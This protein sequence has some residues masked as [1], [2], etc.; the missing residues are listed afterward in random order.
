MKVIRHTRTLYYSDGIQVFEARD[1]IGGHYVAVMVK[2]NDGKEQYLVAGVEPERLQQ[3]RIGM[4]DL[5]S[6]LTRRG[7]EEWFLA[8]ANGGL[9]APLALQAQS[10]ALSA[11]SYLPERGFLLHNN[12]FS[13]TFEKYVRG[14]LDL[15]EW[16]Q[17]GKAVLQALVKK[18][19]DSTVMTLDD[20]R[21]A[22]L[23]FSAT[24]KLLVPFDREPHTPGFV[25]IACASWWD[26]ETKRQIELKI[27]ETKVSR[28]MAAYVAAMHAFRQRDR[29]SALRWASL[30]Y[31][32]DMLAGAPR[33]GG[34]EVTLRFGLRVPDEA[35]DA[36]DKQAKHGKRRSGVERLPEWLLAEA[37]NDPRC[38]SLVAPSELYS[39]HPCH[40]FV[41]AAA[42]HVF[43]NKGKSVKKGEALEKFAAF[44]VSTVPGMRPKRRVLA[45]GLTS[46]HDVV[47]TMFGESPYP[48]PG[49]AGEWLIECKNCNYSASAKEVGHFLAKM[50]HTAAT[51]GIILAKEDVTGGEDKAGERFRREFSMREG[52]VCLVLNS[53]DLTGLGDSGTFRRLIDDKYERERFGK[54]GSV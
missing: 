27:D 13:A 4:L 5:R 21:D 1:G 46:E 30:G 11:S 33:G 8:N 6:L 48:L 51:F 3:F 42:K 19:A 44:L 16:H 31:L 38:V 17:Q 45:Q 7:E 22:W 12:E 47:A 36:L 43:S 14:G 52:I 32:F 10:T 37:L 23:N 24:L 35:M 54:P 26:S 2:P 20:L 18:T 49:K 53:E 40:P 25:E 50:Q 34:N 15:R 28:G 9:D 29:G 41:K 39:H